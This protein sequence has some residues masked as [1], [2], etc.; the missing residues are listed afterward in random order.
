MAPPIEVALLDEIASR[1]ST[2]QDL[3]EA[4]Q[5]SGITEPIEPIAVTST[6]SVIRAVYGSWFSVILINDGPDDLYALVNNPLSKDWHRVPVGETYT[7]NMSKGIL[8]S[9][10]LRCDLEKTASA[11]LVGCR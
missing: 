10:L 4:R 11:R 5:P 3:E 8:G 9:V 1:L 6:V 2:L 7:V